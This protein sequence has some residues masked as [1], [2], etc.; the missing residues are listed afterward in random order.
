MVELARSIND[1]TSNSDTSNGVFSFAMPIVDPLQ[2]LS[3]AATFP[4]AVKQLSHYFLLQD[5]PSQDLLRFNYENLHTNLSNF[6]SQRYSYYGEHKQQFASTMVGLLAVYSAII[7]LIALSSI[8]IFL[9][10]KR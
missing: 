7:F 8:P 9:Y 1:N 10:F 2:Q 4:Q 6:Y 3:Y 5:R